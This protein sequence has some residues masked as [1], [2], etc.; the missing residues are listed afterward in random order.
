MKPDAPGPLSPALGPISC[1]VGDEDLAED[2]DLNGNSALHSRGSLWDSVLERSL[3]I[4]D[5]DR[6]SAAIG[7]AE[8]GG[9]SYEMLERARSEWRRIAEAALF[10]ALRASSASQ[11]EVARLTQAL[12]Q[13]V[14]AGACPETVLQ[15]RA[16]L[17]ELKAA[18]RPSRCISPS[19]AAPSS[20]SNSMV[21]LHVARTPSPR[22]SASPTRG[23]EVAAEAATAFSALPPARS[24]PGSPGRQSSPGRVVPQVL[25]RSSSTDVEAGI[26]KPWRKQ[27]RSPVDKMRGMAQAGVGDRVRHL[28]QN[29]ECTLQ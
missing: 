20:S 12:E 21:A 18:I 23:A 25:G 5:V 11:I 24:K 19:R 14:E 2:L 16:H 29:A 1:N 13:A 28:Q 26:N 10:E 7:L 17:R 15:A 4:G 8:D 3:E 6:I 27:S 22:Q 9:A